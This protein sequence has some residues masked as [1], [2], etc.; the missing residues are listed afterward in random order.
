MLEILALVWLTNK[1]GKT[2]EAKGHKSGKYK[3][4]AVGLWFGG[5]I[6]GVIIGSIIGAIAG[7]DNAQCIAYIVALLGAITGAVIANSIANNVEPVQVI[8]APSNQLNNPPS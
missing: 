1:I 7:G 4:T 3:W 2:V 8:P 6:V 5:E